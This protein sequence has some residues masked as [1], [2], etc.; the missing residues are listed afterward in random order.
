MAIATPVFLSS[1]ISS[2]FDYE[3]KNI[4]KPIILFVALLVAAGTAYLFVVLRFE[5]WRAGRGLLG[6]VFLLGLL[7]RTAF[8]GSTPI[9]EDDHYRYLWDGGVVSAGFNPYRYAPRD[10]LGCQ[11]DTLPEELCRL[12]KEAPT[13][14]KRINYPWLRTIYPPLSQAAFALAHHTRPWSLDAWRSILLVLDILSFYL[15]FIILRNFHFSLE[16]LVIYWWNPLLVKEIYNSGHMD[17]LL[18]P[19]LLGCFLLSCRG[20]VVLASGMLGLAVGAKFWPVLL[21]P[22]ILRPIL[23]RARILLPALALFSVISLVMFLPLYLGGLDSRSGFVAYSRFWEMNDTLFMLALWSV[24][25]FKDLMGFGA[26]SAQIVTRA[27]VAGVLLLVT[28]LLVKRDDQRPF[29]I[30]RR[31]LY[32]IAALYLLSPTQFPWYSIW[33]LPFLAIQPRSSLLLLTVLLPLY[34]L[35]FHFAARELVEVHDNGVVWL[36]FVPVWCLLVWEWYRERPKKVPKSAV[37]AAS[38]PF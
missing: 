10:V 9:L 35:R 33:M 30:G 26:V 20:K 36:Q 22:L 3:F 23:S 7:M 28:V 16:G 19:L 2:R 25:G 24:E 29:M 8:F 14:L 17:L 6:W 21:L 32:M 37:S 13:I 31:F 4:D 18:V 1:L 11:A 15:L 34:Y 27:F 38:T 12:G 5:D